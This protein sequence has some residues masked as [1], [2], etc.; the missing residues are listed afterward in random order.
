MRSLILPMH[1]LGGGS[2]L[3][4]PASL[5]IAAGTAALTVSFVVLLLAWRSPRFGDGRIDR[6]V[7]VPLARIF[8]SI[9]LS[10]LLRASGLAFFCFMLWPALLG[11]DS[12]INPLFGVIYVWL[13]VGLVPA[14]LL[15][16]R[17]YRAISPV[18]T[19]YLLLARATGQPPSQ[20]LREYPAWLGYWPAAIGLFAFVWLELV[21]PDSTYLGPLR[22][23]MALYLAAMVVGSAVFGDRWLERADPFEVYSTLLA[24]L[25][26]WG[27]DDAGRLVWVSPLRH[28]SRV[29]VEG[30]LIA[31]V[32]V[33]LGSTA[34]DSWRGS[35]TWI[36]F[37][38]GSNVSPTTWGTLGLLV[39]ILIVGVTFA[40]ASMATG[41]GRV[42]RWQVPRRLAH[43]VVPIIVGYMVAHYLSFFVQT[44]QLTLIQIS[45][46]LGDGSNLF[47]TA[48]W[49]VNY[50]LAQH[51]TFLAT[52]KVL[53]IVTGHVL[54]VVAA[55]DRAL[56]ILP[57]RHQVT[58]QLPLLF[59]MVLY[60]FMGLYLLFGS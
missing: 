20:G 32:A 7:P 34:Y 45:D 39:A 1:G 57:K 54:G 25:S 15:L 50:W 6:M 29:P 4:I 9:G 16:G 11:P 33:L 48:D 49:Q 22:L 59:A 2:D 5:A 56:E 53:A 24:H 60:T 40:A 44:G 10:M 18:R 55:H 17:F 14:S 37:L 35:A 27:R 46:P 42:D 28:L 51:P 3:P 30:G 23:W 43:S 31:V 13:W 47:G 38:Q 19:L 26:P 8:D 12:L 21:S 36:R 58:G 41:V 52:T